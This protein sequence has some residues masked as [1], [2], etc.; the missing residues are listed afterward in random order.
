MMMMM[1]RCLIGAV[2]HYNAAFS[3]S[4]VAVLSAVYKMLPAV[5]VL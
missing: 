5:C 3:S 1:I 4:I 2:P